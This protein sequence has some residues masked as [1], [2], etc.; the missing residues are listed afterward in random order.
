MDSS[1]ENSS[2]NQILQNLKHTLS[3]LRNLDRLL[4]QT[5]DRMII[6]TQSIYLQRKVVAQLINELEVATIHCTTNALSALN[7][8]YWELTENIESGYK[9]KKANKAKSHA[10]NYQTDNL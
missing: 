3:G 2:K 5:E 6:E 9:A 7:D 10:S 4:E 1:K 8:K